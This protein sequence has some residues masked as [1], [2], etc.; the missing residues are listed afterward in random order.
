M[1]VGIRKIKNF[2]ATQIFR[3]INFGK[4]NSSAKNI[5]ISEAL[6]LDFLR[7]SAYENCQS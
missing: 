7:I 2:T 6:N 3:E 5:T 1:H 4:I